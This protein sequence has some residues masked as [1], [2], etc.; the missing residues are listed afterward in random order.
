MKTRITELFGIKHPIILAGMAYVSTPNLVATVANAGGLGILAGQAYNPDEL[1][2]AIIETRALTDKP[3]GV[4]IL[5]ISPGAI[6]RVKVAIEQKVPILNYA[7]GKATDIIKAVHEYDG[8]VIATVAVERHA[9]RSEQ[10]GADAITATG[11]EA[12]AH[13]GNIASLVLVPRISSLVGVPVIAA[14]GFCDGKGLAAALVLGADAI[15]MGSRFAMTK[16][17]PI[18]EHFKQEILKATMED[19][20]YS[21]KFD[22]LPGRALKTRTTEAIVKRKVPLI[23]AVTDALRFK[24]ELQFS[25]GELIRGIFKMRK[26]EKASL[27]DLARLPV[28]LSELRRA[29]TNG[30][31]NGIMMIGQDCGRIED[32][33]TCAEVIEQVIAEAEEVLAKATEKA[34]S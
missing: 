10:D 3:F 9:L 14:G 7:L 33:P 27:I 12:A 11:N 5:L 4:N 22:G 16:E 20:I 23:G 24:R 1:R 26:A 17:S 8:K 18:H 34:Q 29:I 6:D 15:S 30:D 31:E 32:I 13:G 25:T 19:T 2:Q 21:A 28:G